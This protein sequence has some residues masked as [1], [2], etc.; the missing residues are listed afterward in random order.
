MNFTYAHLNRFVRKTKIELNII[1][2]TGHS[3]PALISN[4]Y[5]NGG[6]DEISNGIDIQ[7]ITKDIKEDYDEL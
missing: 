2:G 5:I 3:L 6:L 7:S 4:R 1:I